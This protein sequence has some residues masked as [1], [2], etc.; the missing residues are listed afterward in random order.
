M[1]IKRYPDNDAKESDSFSAS[2]YTPENAGDVMYR[3]KVK[4]IEYKSK[5]RRVRAED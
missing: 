5:G 3:R 4:R 1:S 2:K